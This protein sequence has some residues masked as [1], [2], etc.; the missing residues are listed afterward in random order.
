MNRIA[1]TACL[2]VAFITSVVL[3][4]GAPL[5]PRRIVNPPLRLRSATPWGTDFVQLHYELTKGQ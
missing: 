3:G 2:A 5:L 4:G 1:V